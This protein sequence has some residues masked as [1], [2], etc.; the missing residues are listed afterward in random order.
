MVIID[1][2]SSLTKKLRKFL[3]SKEVQLPDQG[4]PKKI[5][6]QLICFF[7]FDSSKLSALVPQEHQIMM[8]SNER[9]K[10]RL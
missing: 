3:E 9:D 1:Q 8:R 2:R 6:R 4:A 5:N 10:M 7:F